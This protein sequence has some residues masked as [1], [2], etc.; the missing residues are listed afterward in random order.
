MMTA[1]LFA[2][3][4]LDHAGARL[5]SLVFR[6][7]VLGLGWR[8]CMKPGGAVLIE[9]SGSASSTA[10][11]NAVLAQLDSLADCLE[12]CFILKFSHRTLRTC[13]PRCFLCHVY[14]CCGTMEQQ[15]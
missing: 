8:I 1:S 9:A 15:S 14:V 13:R 6:K 12:V 11:C 5:Q 7:Y 10:V 2:H 4:P 3:T